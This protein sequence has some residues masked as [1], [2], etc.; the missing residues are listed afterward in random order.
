MSDDKIEY[1]NLYN[2]IFFTI[3]R[4]KFPRICKEIL[5]QIIGGNEDDD[6]SFDLDE[7]TRKFINSIK[8]NYPDIFNSTTET[9]TD[10]I[11]DIARTLQLNDNINKKYSALDNTSLIVSYLMAFK[12][13]KNFTDDELTIFI[14]ELKQLINDAILPKRTDKEAEA[15]LAEQEAKDDVEDQKEYKRLY[16]EQAASRAARAAA[17]EQE[18]AKEIMRQAQKAE[19]NEWADMM[20]KHNLEIAKWRQQEQ[21][22]D[23]AKNL[24]KREKREQE[25]VRLYRIAQEKEMTRLEE[26]R[27]NRKAQS[28]SRASLLAR[29]GGSRRRKRKAT[30]KLRKHYKSRKSTHKHIRRKK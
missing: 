14:F 1:E 18:K 22:K 26:E 27:K 17:E 29:H 7:T 9:I 8:E 19:A 5:P 11:R 20:R 24:L 30:R 13:E 6:E 23:K 3:V 15:W 21:Q 12:K 16:G 4:S 28:V 10:G 2:K 25:F